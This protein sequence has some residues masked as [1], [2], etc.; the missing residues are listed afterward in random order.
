MVRLFKTGA[1][2]L[3]LTVMLLAAWGGVANGATAIGAPTSAQSSNGVMHCSHGETP[4]KAATVANGLQPP[5]GFSPAAASDADLAK[6]GFPPRPKS[7]NSAGWLAAMRAWKAKAPAN[8]PAWTC[9]QESHGPAGASRGVTPDG[10][11]G[12]GSYTSHNWG[13]NQ[14][15]NSQYGDSYGDYPSASLEMNLP[16]PVS[17]PN[18]GLNY[19]RATF[20]TGIGLGSGHGST[21]GQLVQNGVEMNL[22]PGSFSYALWFEVYPQQS[23]VYVE[24]FTISYND[25]LYFQSWYSGGTAHFYFGNLSHGQS[26]SYSAA[27]DGLTG[28]SAEWIV[29]KSGDELLTGW[30]PDNPFDMRAEFEGNNGGW[31]CAGTAYH[32]SIHMLN[33]SNQDIAHG[34]A[35]V[36]PPSYC[37]FP[38]YRTSAYGG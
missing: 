28:E 3:A 10:L 14:V 8:S 9:G 27:F 29:E 38:L 31:Y 15:S 16:I 12:S 20:W 2:S 25:L 24:P 6:Y 23:A 22:I 19:G 4:A 17:G 18:N 33:S 34:G 7:G 30:G 26:A 5:A 32:W 11:G 1:G 21:G 37:T 36:D 35:W 13:G